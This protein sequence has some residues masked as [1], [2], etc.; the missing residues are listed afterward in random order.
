MLVAPLRQLRR[1]TGELAETV[2]LW[3]QLSLRL[4]RARPRE[5]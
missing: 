1:E 5:A 3:G 2:R 4:R